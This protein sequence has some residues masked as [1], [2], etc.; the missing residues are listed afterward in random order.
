MSIGLLATLFAGQG[1][2]PGSFTQFEYRA[3]LRGGRLTG[4]SYSQHIGIA[5]VC[6]TCSN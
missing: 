4:L 5:K 6:F 1:I 3:M 2:V